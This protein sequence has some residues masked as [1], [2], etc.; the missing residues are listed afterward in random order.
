MKPLLGCAAWAAIIALAL[1]F[2]LTAVPAWV[3]LTIGYGLT[4]VA[5]QSRAGIRW[6]GGRL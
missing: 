6:F 4:V 5:D 3:F 1:V 2:L